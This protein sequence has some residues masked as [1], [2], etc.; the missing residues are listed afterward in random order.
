M[1]GNIDNLVGKEF[2]SP[3]ALDVSMKV[4]VSKEEGWENH[5][6]RVLEVGENGYTPKHNHPWPH[7]NYILE[8]KGEVTIGDKKTIVT[9]GSYAYVPEGITHQFKNIDK[10]IFKFICIVPEKGHKY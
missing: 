5:V 3:D 7:I 10:G 2:K 9:V 4:L 1:I 6:M 8:G